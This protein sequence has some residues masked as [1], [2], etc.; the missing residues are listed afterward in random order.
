MAHYPRCKMDVR[1]F[2]DKSDDLMTDMMGL[3]SEETSA[4]YLR[5]LIGYEIAHY[6]R[7]LWKRFVLEQFTDV[8]SS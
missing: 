4:R 3:V 8:S 2:M 6:R 7:C 1:H 5:C